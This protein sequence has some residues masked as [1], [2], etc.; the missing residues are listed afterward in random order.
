MRP[1]SGWVPLNPRDLWEYRELLYFLTWRDIKVRYKQ[2]VLGIAWAVIQPLFLMLIFTI[3]FG[4]LARIPSDG[5]PYPI[6]AYTALL[7]WQLFSRAL[8]DAST[9]LVASERLITK[10]YFPRL[11][12]PTSAVLASLVDFA[13]ALVLL[14]GMMVFYG[15]VPTMALIALPLFILFALMTAL[16]MS[17]WLSALNAQYRDIRYVLPFLTQV[18]FFVTPVVYPASMVPEAWRF[19]YGI[20]PMT[21]VVEGF[22]WALL[23]NTE[24]PDATLAVSFTVVLA[25]FIG[26]LYYFTRVEETL[27]DVI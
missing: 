14:L 3:F 9:S 26:S 11:L 19:L 21:G 8:T 20:N 5:M 27:A 7:P 10:I 24:G 17:F 15:M 18:W 23:G 22:R 6:F 4:R 16:G 1:A 13:I 25:V 12:V 2:T